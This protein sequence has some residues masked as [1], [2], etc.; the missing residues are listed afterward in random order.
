[1][2]KLFDGLAPLRKGNSNTHRLPVSSLNHFISSEVE[3]EEST[4][5]LVHPIVPKGGAVLLYGLPKELKSWMGA[6]LALDAASGRKA[7]GFFD[8]PSPVRILYVQVEDPEHLTR[9]RLREL[10][11]KQGARKS[12]AAFMLSVVPRCGLNLLDPEWLAALT[13]AIADSK[14][15]LVILLGGQVKTGQRGSLQ[16]RPTG[17]AQDAILFIPLSLGRASLFWSSNSAVRI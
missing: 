8:V 6:A 11:E 1:V 5:Y 16:N 13:K 12:Y 14:A 2:H 7:L 4:N 3:C 10:H 17:V 9:A 15:K